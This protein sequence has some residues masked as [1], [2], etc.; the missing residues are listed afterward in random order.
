MVT[1]RHLAEQLNVSVSTV[2]KALSNSEEISKDTIERVKALADE[3]NYQ[4]NRV[5]LSLKK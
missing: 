4:P 3:L 1:L 5:A 2:S